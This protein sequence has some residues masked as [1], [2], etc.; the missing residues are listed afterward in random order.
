VNMSTPLLSEVVPEI[1]ANMA[2]FYDGK[3][4]EVFSS[5]QNRRRL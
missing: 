4:K 5:S 2:G 1:D 3:W